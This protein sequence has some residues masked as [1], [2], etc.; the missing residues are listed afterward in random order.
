M[1]GGKLSRRYPSDRSVWSHLVVV[2]APDGDD[3][4]GLRQGFEPV[5]VEAFVPE[6]AVEALDVGVLGGLARLDKDV[7]NT[8]CL[9]PCHEGSACELRSVVGSDGLWV[10]P[11][12]RGLIQDAGDVCARHG[13]VHS[14][15]YALTG[16]VIGDGQALDASAIGQ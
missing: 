3:L 7:L 6:L 8:S 1:L 15:V 11:E 16:E 12:P 2:L 14:D 10:A 4:A 13:Q 5:L 9:H